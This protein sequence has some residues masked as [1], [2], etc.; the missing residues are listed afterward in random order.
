MPSF[1]IA[2]NEQQTLVH[3]ESQIEILQKK[4]EELFKSG[5]EKDVIIL[6]YQ[7]SA[8]NYSNTIERL[9]MKLQEFEAV[10]DNNIEAVESRNIRIQ[11][12]EKDLEANKKIVQKQ[13]E[14]LGAAHD[15]VTVALKEYDEEHYLD[16][17]NLKKENEET[18][19]K[20]QSQLDASRGDNNVEIQNLR[21]SVKDFEL[22][23]RNSVQA[24]N[25]ANAEL[26]ALKEETVAIRENE[27]QSSRIAS[28]LTE[29]KVQQQAKIADLTNQ[30]TVLNSELKEAREELEEAKKPKPPTT[31]RRRK[32][33]ASK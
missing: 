31:S 20:L 3:Y 1:F 19:A 12:L 29:L 2:M 26:S 8:G 7:K 21:K 9:T 4:L 15:Q 24:L 16:M 11:E 27:V 23:N 28:Q 10:Q 22:A 6:N 33:V 17:E 30:L 14:E 25:K 5:V 32:P 13:R 18:I